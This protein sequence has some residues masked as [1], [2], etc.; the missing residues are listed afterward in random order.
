M[1]ANNEIGTIQPIEEIAKICKENKILFHSDMV[2]SFGKIPINL[3]NIDL[4]SFSGHKIHGPKGIGI[5]YIKKGTKIT[6]LLHGGGHEFNLRSS[7]ENIPSIIGLAKAIEIIFKDIQTEIKRQ[8]ELRNYLIEELLKIPNS[9]L[10]G[11]KEKR[12]PNNVNISFEFIEGESLVFKLNFKNIAASTGSACS[13]KSLEPS[14]V[15]LAIGLK[16]EI[17]HGSLRLTLNKDTTKKALDYTIKTIKQDRK[18][19]V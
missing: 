10:N 11:H 2:Q 17:A 3:T 9:R 19:V 6:P 5:L 16:P 18:S 15:L 8:S 14:H 12:L 1:H 4:A 13:S 7:T